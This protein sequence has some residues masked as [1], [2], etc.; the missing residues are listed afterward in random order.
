M[1]G[2]CMDFSNEI[3]VASL[4]IMVAEKKTANKELTVPNFS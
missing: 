2:L 3:S 1:I 4:R